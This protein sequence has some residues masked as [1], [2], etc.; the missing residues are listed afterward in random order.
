[1]LTIGANSTGFLG[2]SYDCS[3]RD[4]GDQDRLEIE[5]VFQFMR[6]CE[7]NKKL[8]GPEH[9]RNN[10][11][12][13]GDLSTLGKRIWNVQERRPYYSNDISFCQQNIF[14]CLSRG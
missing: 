13:S 9:K 11:L 6:W 2:H 12:L 4:D 14:N 3:N 1:M 7:H 8:S 5:E 10:H